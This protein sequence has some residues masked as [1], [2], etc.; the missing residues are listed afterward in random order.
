MSVQSFDLGVPFIISPLIVSF[1]LMRTHTPVLS[2]PPLSVR[3][4]LS[5]A[6]LS[7]AH[8]TLPRKDSSF[9]FKPPLSLVTCVD[10]GIHL[11]YFALTSLNVVLI[12]N[13]YNPTT[14]FYRCP[15]LYM[16]WCYIIITACFMGQL[17]H[18]QE[19][20]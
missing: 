7:S 8:V 9:L 1:V 20:H 10:R 4:R 18:W 13:C 16:I 12:I 3:T 2:H 17:L 15:F 19:P 14:Y 5:T 11:P 6:V